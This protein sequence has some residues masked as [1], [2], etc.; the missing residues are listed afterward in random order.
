MRSEIKILLRESLN[1]FNDSIVLEDYPKSFDMDFFKSLKTFKDRINYCGEHLKR[2]SA[3]TSRIVYQIDDE[4]VL[5]LARNKK[6]LA[7][8]EVEVDF[9]GE[10]MLED[11]LAKVFDYHPNF[12]WVEMEL[13]RKV[14]EKIFKEI[15]GYS[16]G[17]YSLAIN[18]YYYDAIKPSPFNVKHVDGTEQAIANL[19]EDE[20][21]YSVFQYLGNFNVPVGDL[22]K[23]ST[24]GLVKRDGAEQIVLIDYGLDHNTLEKYYS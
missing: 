13:A 23:L 7:Q 10:H 14:T 9:S 22:I 8:N 12:E 2:I 5:K 18:N 4:K 17:L 1:E 16:F 21:A 15:N 19:W 20:F 24:Y 3:G 6:G 11:I